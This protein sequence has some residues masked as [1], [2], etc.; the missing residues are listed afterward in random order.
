MWRDRNLRTG[1]LAIAKPSSAVTLLS[2]LQDFQANV[3]K[4]LMQERKGQ[5]LPNS[6]L[7]SRAKIGTYSPYAANP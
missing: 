1:L 2:K 4:Q 3:L 5:E 7:P 6:C